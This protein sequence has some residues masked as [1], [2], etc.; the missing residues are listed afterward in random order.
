MKCGRIY[1]RVRR[2]KR[3]LVMMMGINVSKGGN[4]KSGEEKRQP[5][6][7][8][9]TLEDLLVKAGVVLNVFSRR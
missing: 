9:I 6:L 3:M 1:N 2:R 4:F 8:E 5:T 7:R